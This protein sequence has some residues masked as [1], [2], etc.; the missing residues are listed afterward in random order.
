MSGRSPEGLQRRAARHHIQ[1]PPAYYGARYG[2]RMW[3][4]M[5]RRRAWHESGIVRIIVIFLVV[6]FILGSWGFPILWIIIIVAVIFYFS[7]KKQE[8]PRSTPYPQ[9][10]PGRA[11]TYP[12][13]Q[14]EIASTS[15]PRQQPVS[16]APYPTSQRRVSSTP[17]FIYPEQPRYASP[18]SLTCYSCG[19]PLNPEDKFCAECGRSISRCK[20]CR[21]LIGFGDA[22]SQCPHCKNEFHSEHIKEWLKVSGDCPVCR[23]RIREAE[24]ITAVQP[25]GKS[26]HRAVKAEH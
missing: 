24:L 18:A 12:Q 19:Q 5:H 14:R 17:V 2:P 9:A 21:G 13:R 4:P 6:S 3:P 10:P 1:R 8:T 16:R 11:S 22:L 15:Y 25:V 7:R 26:K 20:I 23:Q